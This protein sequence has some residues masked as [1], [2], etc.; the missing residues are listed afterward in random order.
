M[1]GS[2]AVWWPFR[3]LT[4]GTMRMPPVHPAPWWGGGVSIL[5]D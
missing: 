1:R 3:W 4:F 5:G 2:V